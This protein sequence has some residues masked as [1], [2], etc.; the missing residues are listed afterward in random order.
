[1][2]FVGQKP[3]EE[4]PGYLKLFDVGIIPYKGEAFLNSCQPTK[5]FEYLAAGLGVVSAPIPELRHCAE[6]VRFA[7]DATEFVQ[8]TQAMLMQARN[9]NFRSR[10][11]A[12]ARDRTWDARVLAASELVRAA[13]REVRRAPAGCTARDKN[14]FPHAVRRNTDRVSYPGGG[15]TGLVP[16]ADCRRR[17]RPAPLEAMPIFGAPSSSGRWGFTW[18]IGGHVQFSH[19]ETFDRY[20]DQAL[21]A[22]GWHA[23]ARELVWVRNRFVP[24]IPKQSA[25]GP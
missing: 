11:V 18:D 21:G 12:I 17:D 23:P 8:Q 6:V 7:A 4:L 1:M 5:T 22:D 3:P 2:R 24:P 19:Y 9:A 14:R 25:P 15:P 10:C 16:P 13:S 20:M